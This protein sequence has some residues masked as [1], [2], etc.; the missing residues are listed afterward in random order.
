MSKELV[1]KTKT[2][3]SNNK[4]CD[5]LSLY[6]VP[7]MLDRIIKKEKIKLLNKLECGAVVIDSLNNLLSSEDFMVE[8]PSGLREMLKS[9]KAVF[10][11][12]N[13]N[14]GAF[15]PNI[16]IK[17]KAGIK[18]QAS[19]VK[20]VDHQVITRNLSN[21]AM[22]G[23]VQSVLEKLE[24][25]EEKLEDVKQ[26]QKNDRVGIVIGY[27]KAFVDLYPTFKSVEEMRN[28]ANLAYMGMQSGLS[29]LH[30]QI[31]AERKK[32]EDK[33]AKELKAKQCYIYSDVDGIY[34]ADPNKIPNA[35]K[36]KN[37]SYEEMYELSSEGAK[38]LHD[39]CV[40]IGERFDVP[41]VTE[42]TFNNKPGTQ[43]THKLECSGI[44]SIV[45]KD[46]SRISVIGFGI[47]S[48]DNTLKKI[49]KIADQHSLE[50]FNIDISRTKISIVFKEIVKDNVL[51][52]IHDVLI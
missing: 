5:I 13:I 28:A 30:L 10:D 12:S 36:L 32:L 39:R 8:I 29:K 38:V 7:T 34:T 19:I 21:L 24:A 23:M 9:G 17:G 2:E 52:E 51:Q 41:I 37:I 33:Y 27:F 26:G 46:V 18:G 40:E 35:D 25:I 43:I 49:L 4:Q 48:N 1:V 47:N 50:I 6:G 16:R 15:T 22:M 45:K 20:K 11:K 3:V 42:S 44:K 14:P 31:D